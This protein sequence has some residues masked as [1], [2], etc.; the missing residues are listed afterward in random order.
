MNKFIRS[1]VA[2]TVAILSALVL[3]GSPASEAQA[4]AIV[5]MDDDLAVCVSTCAKKTKTVACVT[6]DDFS[7]CLNTVPECSRLSVPSRDALDEFCNAC[8]NAS[9]RCRKG[10][11]RRA[12]T[13]GTPKTASPPAS[14]GSAAPPAAPSSSSAPAPSVPPSP[15]PAPASATDEE[16]CRKK[17]GVWY[18]EAVEDLSTDPPTGKVIEH[19]QTLEHALDRIVKLERAVRMKQAGT[20]SISQEDLAELDRL[21]KMQLPDDLGRR[22]REVEL[23][24]DVLC[25]PIEKHPEAT[26]KQRCLKFLF[27]IDM[28][29][30]KADEA[31]ETARYAKAQAEHAQKRINDLE[32][33]HGSAAV[34]G[35]YRPRLRVSAVTTWHAFKTPYDHEAVWGAGFEAAYMPNLTPNLSLF[36]LGGIGISVSDLM[37][38]QRPVMWGGMGLSGPVKKDDFLVEGLLYAEHWYGS[39]ERSTLNFYG[40]GGGF[41][42]MPG[43]SVR[44]GYSPVPAFGIRAILGDTRIKSPGGGTEDSFD[45]VAAGHA[46]IAF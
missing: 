35:G 19:C 14:S 13:P 44:K 31:L 30:V 12:G 36:L 29:E 18:L 32:H 20:G 28:L 22:F 5:I 3:I 43:A 45:V 39:D 4:Q 2:T 34:L 6:F 15:A 23:G 11:A 38:E 46:L 17:G 10:G 37:G 21:R 33:G 16:L 7:A 41:T 42:W 8:G 25:P 27:R 24:L 26:L 1:L 40:V 9:K